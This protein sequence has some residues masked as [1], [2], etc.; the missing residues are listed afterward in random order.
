M[1]ASDLL[2]RS[3]Y[4]RSGRRAG[5]VVEIR[6]VRDGPGGRLR[7]DGVIVARHRMRL[8]GYQRHGES[9]PAL[10]RRVVRWL[11]RDSKYVRWEWIAEVERD[12]LWLDVR[13]GQL[14]DLIDG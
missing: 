10:L 11:H 4:D 14:P 6:A 12:P 13:A 9:G 2:G 1:R 7:T 8:F 5:Y 3:V